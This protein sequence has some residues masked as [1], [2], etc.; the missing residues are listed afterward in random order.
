MGA[1]D[2]V[3]SNFHIH[4]DYIDKDEANKLDNCNITIK[5]VEPVY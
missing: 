4:K 1:V 3:I 2:S 5:F